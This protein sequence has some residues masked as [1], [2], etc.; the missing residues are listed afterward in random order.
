[1][2]DEERRTSPFWLIA[3][4]N[5]RVMTP[6]EFDSPLANAS[7]REAGFRGVSATRLA[8]THTLLVALK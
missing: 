6:G 7:S 1:M 4:L 8:G 5:T 2:I 3:N